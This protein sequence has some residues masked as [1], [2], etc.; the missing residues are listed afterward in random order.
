M[1]GAKFLDEFEL[2]AAK[3]RDG[4]GVAVHLFHAGDERRADVSRKE[5]GNGGAL[6]NVMNERRGRRSRSTR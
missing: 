4:N 3:L 1:S 6:Q 5:G 2:K